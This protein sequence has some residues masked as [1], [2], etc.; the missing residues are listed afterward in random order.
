[1]PI[2]GFGGRELLKALAVSV[3]AFLLASWAG[4]GFA[5]GAGRWLV[6][7]RLA[8]ISLTWLAATLGGLWL[9]RST[10]LQLLRR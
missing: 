1:V 2:T 10:L 9:T 3:F 6:V 8:M 5:Y 4:H 7:G